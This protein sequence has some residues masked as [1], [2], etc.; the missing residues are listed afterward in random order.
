LP[1]QTTK[2]TTGSRGSS[3]NHRESTRTSEKLHISELRGT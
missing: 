1:E 3:S 2:R